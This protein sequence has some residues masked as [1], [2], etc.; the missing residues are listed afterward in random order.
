MFV[1]SRFNEGKYQITSK[2]ISGA[3]SVKRGDHVLLG[4]KTNMLT[5]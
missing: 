2:F 5:T 3:A 4:M 1:F